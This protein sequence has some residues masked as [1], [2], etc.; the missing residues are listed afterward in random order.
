MEAVASRTRSRSS[1][2]CLVM[3]IRESWLPSFRAA[4]ALP[5]GVFEFLTLWA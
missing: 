2:L 1:G 5:R 4:A 3:M